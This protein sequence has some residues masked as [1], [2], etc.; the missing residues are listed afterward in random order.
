MGITEGVI[1]AVLGLLAS[2]IVAYVQ[3]RHTGKKT[4]T[5]M[6]NALCEAQQE[7][8]TQLQERLDR[9][10]AE[11][12]RLRAELV[13]MRTENAALREKIKKLEEERAVLQTQLTALQQQQDRR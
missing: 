6:Y 2:V 1:I 7:R 10:E 9:N 11:L 13:T 12:E 4:A 8:I 5:E 3:S